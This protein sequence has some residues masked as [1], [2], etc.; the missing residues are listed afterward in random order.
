M[1]N[2]ALLLSR[3][4]AVYSLQ[5]VADMLGCDRMRLDKVKAGIIPKWDYG[6]RI[7]LLHDQ[8]TGRDE[9]G[10]ILAKMREKNAEALSLAVPRAVKAKRVAA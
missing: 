9:V 6:L 1:T 2:F 8:I 3:I 4:Q 7:V 10:E 5:E